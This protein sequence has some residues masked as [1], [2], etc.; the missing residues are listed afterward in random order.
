M[1]K[2]SWPALLLEHTYYLLP[3]CFDALFTLKESFATWIVAHDYVVRCKLTSAKDKAVRRQTASHTTP[4]A[5]RSS[6]LKEFRSSFARCSPHDLTRGNDIHQSHART[7]DTYA[8]SLDQSS[9]ALRAVKDFVTAE[10][11]DR[12]CTAHWWYQKLEGSVKDAFTHCMGCDPMK[13]M[14]TDR[15]RPD[16]Y[17]VDPIP[18]MN[19]IYVA[20]SHHENNSDTVFYTQARSIP[21][22]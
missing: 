4:F 7:T 19:E 8:S 10:N 14:F 13:K 22:H 6:F 9:Q 11:P 12:S 1:S 21:S 5:R 18:A 20:S 2:R 15:F 3:L 16:A 17:N